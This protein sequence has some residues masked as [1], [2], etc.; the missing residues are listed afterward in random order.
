MERTGGVGRHGC[1][2]LEVLL[3]GEARRHSR[4][5]LYDHLDPAAGELSRH[6]GY[7]GHPVLAGL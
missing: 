7:E 6:L 1:A 4:P 2:G 5:G 3:V